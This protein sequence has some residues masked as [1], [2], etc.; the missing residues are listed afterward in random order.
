MVVQQNLSARMADIQ[1]GNSFKYRDKENLKTSNSDHRSNTESSAAAL[2]ISGASRG[3]LRETNKGSDDVQS[4]VSRLQVADKSL[5]KLSDMLIHMTELCIQA[6]K[7]ESSPADRREITAEIQQLRI[8]INESGDSSEFNNQKVLDNI[9]V[10]SLGLSDID[11]DT[12]DA[13][14]KSA[15]QVNKALESVNDMRSSIADEKAQ[16]EDAAPSPITYKIDDA[17]FTDNVLKNAKESMLSQIGNDR[18][19]IISLLQ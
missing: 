1:V 9:S 16:L 5:S 13:A 19:I 17:A 7:S 12:P 4:A 2:S 3:K 18:N 14:L 10:D 8:K 11:T 6:S 15:E